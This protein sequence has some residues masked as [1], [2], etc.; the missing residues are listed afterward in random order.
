VTITVRNEGERPVQDLGLTD[1]LTGGAAL[2]SASSPSGDC[3][4]SPSDATCQLGDLAAGANVIAEVHLVLDT[5]PVSRTVSQRI[6]LSASGGQEQITERAVST[7]I[8]DGQEPGSQLLTVPG[9]V[10]TL[11]AFTGFTLAA[12]SPA[13]STSPRSGR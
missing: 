13:T 2:R 5:E 1:R 3:R 12:R 11:I 10:V 8:D 6:T 9:T 4:V 7:L